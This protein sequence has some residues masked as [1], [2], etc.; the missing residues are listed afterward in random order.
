MLLRE[1]YCMIQQKHNIGV[2]LTLD[3]TGHGND[4]DGGLKQFIDRFDLSKK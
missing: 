3:E 1:M 2:F 4:E